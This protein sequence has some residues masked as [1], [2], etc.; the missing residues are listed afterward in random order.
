MEWMI[1][2]AGIL[3]LF[4]TFFG[5]RRPVRRFISDNATGE[6]LNAQLLALAER[7]PK[8]VLTRL[9]PDPR[10]MRRFEKAVIAL[11]RFDPD[12]LPPCARELCNHARFLQEEME[13]AADYPFPPLPAASRK[14]PPRLM[15]FASGLCLGH[16]WEIDQ[17]RIL[18]A[19]STWQ[20]VHLFDEGELTSL[21]EALR[22][23]LCA[24]AAALAVESA[25]D[26]QHRQNAAR[27]IGLLKKG[28]TK[29]ALRLMK[30]AGSASAFW[31]QVLRLDGLNK[32][33]SNT[34]EPWLLSREIRPEQLAVQEHQKQA[35][36]SLWISSLI[37]SLQKLSLQPWSKMEE[38]M[39]LIHR[40]YCQDEVYRSMDRESRGFYRWKTAELAR[41]LRL[42]EG[43]VCAAAL[44]LSQKAEKGVTAHIGYYLLDN[45]QKALFRRLHK[46]QWKT[47]NGTFRRLCFF[48]WTGFGALLFG[49]YLLRLSVLIWLPFAAVMLYSLQQLAIARMQQKAP[50][51]MVPRIHLEQLTEQTLVVCPTVLL[52]P[53]HALSMVK[54]LSVMHQANP[55]PRL[56]F[57]LLGDFQDSLSGTLSSDQEIMQAASAAVQALSADTGHSFFYLQRQRVYSS[58]EHMHISRERK[59]GGV[60]TVLSLVEGKPVKDGFS[61]AT[62]QPESLMGQYRYVITLDSDTLLPPGSA[63]RMIGAMMHPLQKR[64][65]LNGRMRGISVLQPRMETAAHTVYTHLSRLLGGQGGCDPYNQLVSCF[66]QDVLSSGTFMGKGIIDPGPFLQANQKAVIPGTVLSHDLLE[67]ELSGCAT[68]TDIPL[69]D[70]HPQSL[71]GFLNR[72]HRWT[73]GDWQLLA[74]LLPCFPQTWRAGRVL[75]S[76]ARSKLWRNLLRSLIAPLRVLLAAYGAATGRIW[77][78][79]LALLLPEAAYLR[80]TLPAL[81]SLLCRLAVLPC[82]AGMQAD[83]IARTLWRL[84][85]SHQ[86][87]QQWTTS[88]QLSQKP[89]RPSMG[90]FYLS[91][92]SGGTMAA[93][94][95]LPGASM[96]C[97]FATAVLWAGLT[98]ALPFLE[99]EANPLPRPTGYMREVLG[100]IAQK[101]LLFF[102]TTVTADDHALPPDNLQVEPDKGPAHRTSPTNIGLYLCGLIAAEK[103]RL[104]SPDETAGRIQATVQTIELLP[105]WR[106]HLYNWYDTRTLKVLPPAFVSSVDSGN[107]AACLLCCAQ[108]IRALMPELSAGYAGLAARLDALAEGMHFDALYDGQAQLFY[109]GMENGVPT[110]AHYDL[111]A[112]EARLLSYVSILLGQ[113]PIQHWYRLGRQQARLSHGRHTLLSYSGTMFEYLMPLLFLPSVEGTLLDTACRQ[114]LREQEKVR[115]SRAFGISES[116]YYAFDPE[117]NYQYQAFG[118]PALAIDMEVQSSVIAPY[119]TFLA[120]RLDL[121]RAFHNIL[122]LQNM[123]LEGAWGMFEAADFD[124]S[125]CDGRNM[126]IVRSH[127]AHHQGMILCAICNALEGNHLVELFSSLPRAQA[128]RLLLEEKPIRPS[129]RRTKPIQRIDRPGSQMSYWISR[130]A[131]PLCFPVDAHVLSG[132]GTTLLIDAHGGGFLCRQGVMMTRFHESCRIPS[133]IRFYLR[134]SQSG[135]LWCAT[136]PTLGQSVTFETA[137]AV[138]SHQRYDVACQ[139]RLWVN[140]LDGTCVHLLTLQNR[141]SMERMMEVCSYLEPALASLTEDTAHP[142][143]QNLMIQ[144]NRLKRF[145]VRAIRRSKT[146][147]LPDKQLWHLLVTDASLTMF[148]LQTDRTAFIGRGR[149]IRSPRALHFPISAMADSLGDMIEP[150]LSLRGQFILPP[151]GSLRFAFV[152][153]MAD[154]TAGEEAFCERYAHLDSVVHSYETAMTRG[155]VLARFLGMGPDQQRL[156]SRMVGP[157]LYTEQPCAFLHTP[158]R[159]LSP[160]LLYRFGLGGDRPILLAVC[161]TAPQTLPSLLQIHR[162]YRASGLQTHLALVLPPGSPKLEELRETLSKYAQEEGVH[163][164]LEPTEEEYALLLASARLVLGLLEG[165]M[166]EQ[167]DALSTFPQTQP[168][169]Q[170]PSSAPWKPSLPDAPPLWGDNEFGGFTP[171]GNYQM[172]LAPGRQTPAPWCLPLCSSAFGTLAGESGL[173]FSYAG[174]CALG[175]FTRWPNDSVYPLGDEHFFLTDSQ[176]RLIWSLTRLPL[177]QGMPVRIT[178][179]P[180]EAL[181]EASGYGIYS[182]LRCFSDAEETAG[183]RMI[184]LRND[185]SEERRLTLWH[186]CT[187]QP[188]EN[189]RHWQLSKAETTADGLYFSLPGQSGTVGLFGIDPL[190]DQCTAMSAGSFW[191]LWNDAPQALCGS[192]LPREQSGNTA[193]LGYQLCI[194]PGETQTI[195]TCLGHGESREVLNNTLQTIRRQ[196]A[197]QRLHRLRQSWEDRLGVLT[198]DLPDKALSLML[199]RWL[200][201]QV[202]ASRLWMQGG[203]YQAGGAFGF[204]DQLQDMLSLLHTHP[205]EARRHLLLCAQKQFEEGDVLHWWHQPRQG[206]RTRISDDKLFLPYV[207]ALY[208]QCTGDRNVLEERLPYLHGA[209]L[210]NEETDRY[211]SPV[212]SAQTETL[213]QHCLRA[214]YSV[215]FGEHNLPLMGG[216][217]WNDGFNLAGGERGESVW[218]GMFLCEALRLFAPLC[219]AETQLQLNELRER[220]LTALEQSAWDGS[221][222]LRGWYHDG[223]PMGSARS[224]EC[225]IDLLPQCWAVLCGLSRDRSAVALGNVWNMLYEAD[226]GILKLFAPPFDGAETPGYVAGYLPGVRENGGQYTHAACWAVAALH[227]QG[228]DQRA[229]ELALSLLPTRHSATRQLAARYR[230]EPYVMAA[231]VYANPQQRGRGGWTWYTGSASWYRYVVL[232]SL[233][234]FQ[235]QGDTLRFRPVLPPG[236]EEIRLTYRYGTA[237]YHLRAL[238]DCPAPACDGSPLKDGTLLL[239]DD[240]RIHEAVFPF[241]RGT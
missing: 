231:D 149:T 20:T 51:R 67:G 152:T 13:A 165:P 1:P 212:E 52:S 117:L 228:E 115:H 194:K 49:A 178:Y 209:V 108:G 137:Q 157:L 82:E 197:S 24:K 22:L 202:L 55:D 192:V 223:T 118:L 123:G 93:L 64:Q 136:D 140:P 27:A 86:H 28:R 119:A 189:G 237:T 201:Y 179:A 181:Y 53:S 238:R 171:E 163:V 14:A 73:R 169:F 16:Q 226:I 182:C 120:L 19:V 186:T 71:S 70:G 135:S 191:G 173:I 10:M 145:G 221:W 83:A 147:G 69:Y 95:L 48:S 156:A 174:N 122:R 229:W 216:G 17:S 63:L 172:N 167:L 21:R 3:L 204:R 38:D 220:C 132:G 5:F 11:N 74:Y 128:Y 32:D 56:H 60:E 75:D 101:T 89:N 230:V 193:L 7:N 126:R 139:L 198:F 58:A 97:C 103:L 241:R 110:S 106:G 170:A 107:L 219:D 227:Q 240:G 45:G 155:T 9:S 96:L 239:M 187:F 143:F 39:S 33:F 164:I 218:L 62:L 235:K 90:L 131:R 34:L 199:G 29:S 43:R 146:N 6:T 40:D 2:A 215:P 116:G 210:E 18:S 159:P 222:Y 214:I 188:G 85:V 161:E 184:R 236:W 200:P 87:L 134:D 79:L 233:L 213:R 208:V 80:P 195:V 142:C 154:G 44:A 25:Q 91:M 4:L 203:F 8:R 99:Q 162:F 217:D 232:T 225:R 26:Q 81:Q 77:L 185:G 111:L 12:D 196:G 176:Q 183:L 114:A 205:A 168:A 144:T 98:F 94:G 84:F 113:I 37:Q 104:L 57:L 177:G 47:A 66:D 125:R 190:P 121:K 68:A 151:G 180:G 150:C 54:R 92:G 206:V 88:D 78:W 175:R 166:E 105:K 141:T 76:T 158:D 61:C 30:K 112:S 65:Q 148:R 133:G 234:G 102:E 211:F 207:T 31:E 130:E 127:M 41:R 124:S 59:R 42:S 160:S 109:I 35:A 138:F 36:D 46:T 72:L 15:M 224:R 50:P 153:Q 100:R 23:T 129:R